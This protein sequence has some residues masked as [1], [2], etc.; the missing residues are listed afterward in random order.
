MLASGTSKLRP[1]TQDLLNKGD[2]PEQAKAGGG[3]QLEG[4]KGTLGVMPESTC[5]VLSQRL[6]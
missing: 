1:H 4:P 3:A 6:R 2:D 5:R